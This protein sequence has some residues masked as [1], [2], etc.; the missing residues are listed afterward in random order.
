MKITSAIAVYFITW[1]LCLF[2]TLPIGVRNAHEAGVDVKQ[3]HEPGAPVAPMLWR[4]VGITTVLA[5]IVFLLVYGEVTR[6]W[7]TF[8]DVPWL[9]GIADGK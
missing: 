5:T 3:G 2:L 1:W 4:K 7:I 9:S 6:G 8:N